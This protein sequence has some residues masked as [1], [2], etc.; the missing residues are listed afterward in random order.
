[1]G[2]LLH[3]FLLLLWRIATSKPRLCIDVNYETL[4]GDLNRRQWNSVTKA[5]TEL[6]LAT[7]SLRRLSKS[8][9]Q[10][11]MKTPALC[12]RF[13]IWTLLDARA[14]LA[15]YFRKAPDTGGVIR[16]AF[17]SGFWVSQARFKCAILATYRIAI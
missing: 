16:S 3:M 6:L 9:L 15:E 11:I 12:L 8:Q 17:K 5:Q 4:G 7:I 13:E 10:P 1:M 14:V 2:L